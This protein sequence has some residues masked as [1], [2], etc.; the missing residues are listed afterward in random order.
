MRND[1][2]RPDALRPLTIEPDEN[3]VA[4]EVDPIAGVA[5]RFE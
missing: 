2:R 3:A 1:G 5:V 4:F